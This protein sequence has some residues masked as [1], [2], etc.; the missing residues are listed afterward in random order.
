[1]CTKY[2]VGFTGIRYLPHKNEVYFIDRPR[3]DRGSL[4]DMDDQLTRLRLREVRAK[5]SFLFVL[6]ILTL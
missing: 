1:M 2:F 5:V 4:V 6:F 3:F